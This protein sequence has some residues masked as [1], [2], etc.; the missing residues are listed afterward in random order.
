MNRKLKNTLGLLGLLLFILIAGGIYI[1]VVQRGSIAENTKKL[2]ELNSHSM[3]KAKLLEELDRMKFRAAELDSILA[4]RKFNIPKDISSIK[5]YTFVNGLSPNFSPDMRT[6]IE[7]VG[8]KK[9]KEFDFFEY[10]VTGGASYNDLYKFLYS[11]EHSKEL[12]KINSLALSNLVIED[13]R[14]VPQFF[15]GYTMNVI[16]LF[17]KE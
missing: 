9:D 17:I 16:C 5:F 1:F 11:I 10:K 15:V 7:Y 13:K 12:K 2:A 14:G 4:S 8:K 6:N 3:E